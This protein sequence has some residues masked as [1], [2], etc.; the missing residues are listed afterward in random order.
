MT[1]NGVAYVGTAKSFTYS[2]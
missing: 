1:L 2:Q